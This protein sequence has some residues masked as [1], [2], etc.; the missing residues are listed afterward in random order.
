LHL[1]FTRIQRDCHISLSL[2]SWLQITTN[3]LHSRECRAVEI[4]NKA[5][6]MRFS[7]GGGIGD[8]VLT[9]AQSPQ[10]REPL[11]QSTYWVN[12]ILRLP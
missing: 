10:E 11:Q 4:P 6:D 7:T 1:T 8:G 2:S 5:A 12:A 9:Q 3:N